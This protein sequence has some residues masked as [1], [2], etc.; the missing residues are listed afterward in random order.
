MKVID[1]KIKFNDP[2]KVSKEA[3]TK[4]ISNSFKLAHKLALRKDVMGIINCPI[5]KTFEENLGV[6]ELLASKCKVKNNSE[7]MLIRNKEV[8][9][10]IQHI[11]ISNLYQAK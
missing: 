11:L 10:P 1:I 7:V 2:F 8:S 3:S 4:F 9:S 6:T 5:N